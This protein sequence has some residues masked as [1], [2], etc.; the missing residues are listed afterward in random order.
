MESAPGYIRLQA[1]RKQLLAGG[2]KPDIFFSSGRILFVSS[3]RVSGF[4]FRCDMV[5][6]EGC[7]FFPI[8][9]EASES[10]GKLRL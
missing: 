1:H 7:E 5:H 10:G 6:F 4:D 2:G 8:F 9:C 3:R